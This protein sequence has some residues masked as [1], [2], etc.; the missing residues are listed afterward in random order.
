MTNPVDNSETVQI[1]TAD[2]EAAL[3]ETTDEPITDPDPTVAEAALIPDD[4]AQIPAVVVEPDPE[5]APEPEAP[6]VIELPAIPVP[7]P[8]DARQR[9]IRTAV[10]A[11]ISSA[12][13]LLIVVPLVLD[14]L[15]GAVPASTYAVLASGAAAITAGATVVT[16][17]MANPTVSAL[18]SQYAPWLSA[19][20]PVK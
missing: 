18:I 12:A 20:P 9:K 2:I 8:S 6:A 19:T 3:A 17:I 13:V 14:V 5:P 10:Q 7:V 1:A 16:H 11:F 4:T 15:H